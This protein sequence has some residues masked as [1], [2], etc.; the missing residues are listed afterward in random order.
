MF[1]KEERSYQWQGQLHRDISAFRWHEEP[2]DALMPA[3]ANETFDIDE[4][5]RGMM[6]ES[7]WS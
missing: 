6:Q 5:S 1:L 3:V 2:L 4:A 7:R